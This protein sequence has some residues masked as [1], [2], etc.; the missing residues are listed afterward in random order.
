MT[1]PYS[2]IL[3]HEYF[4]KRLSEIDEQ[5]QRL[6]YALRTKKG[7]LVVCDQLRVLEIEKMVTMRLYEEM[8]MLF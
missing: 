2:R 4:Y 3:I 5:E 7:L 6:I 8:K 1:E